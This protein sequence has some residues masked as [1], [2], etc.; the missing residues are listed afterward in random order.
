MPL[1][2]V[3]DKL[4]GDRTLVEASRPAGALNAILADRFDVS[5][6]LD[7]GVAVRLATHEK[8]PFVTAEGD[9]TES[10]CRDSPTP[11]PTPS[12]TPTPPSTP[13]PENE[14]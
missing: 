6:Q 14:Q 3:T 9:T 2:L 4:N 10:V 7:A 8:V 5:T 11:P 12:P 1:Y 13:T